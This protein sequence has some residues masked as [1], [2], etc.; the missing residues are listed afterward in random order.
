MKINVYINVDT[1]ISSG[2]IT[3]ISNIYKQGFFLNRK[4]ITNIL[5]A[6]KKWEDQMKC[7]YMLSPITQN[8][9]MQKMREI[10]GLIDFCLK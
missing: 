4:P 2:S 9:C 5:E 1:F 3:N 10:S 6:F 8:L 7:R